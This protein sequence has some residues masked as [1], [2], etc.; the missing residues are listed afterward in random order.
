MIERYLRSVRSGLRGVPEPEIE[1]ILAELRGH[2][3]E[4]AEHE[5]E[6]PAVAAMGPPD[7]LA[8]LYLAE[9]IAERVERDRSP[10]PVFKAAV[11]IA[12]LGL[13]AMR[14][15]FVSAGA[16][17]LGIFLLV[18]AAMKPFMPERIGL[19]LVEDPFRHFSL[20]YRQPSGSPGHEML[21]WW[22]VPLW[23]LGAAMLLAFAWRNSLAAIRRLGRARSEIMA[24][25]E[26]R[27]AK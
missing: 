16:T 27:P 17:A 3:L 19:F 21:G 2:L 25:R 18:H 5:G 11:Q 14:S 23:L 26:T 1:D 8:R 22:I 15:L 10:V 13:G 6:V 7:E 20:A 24:G 9:R 12:G 4:Q